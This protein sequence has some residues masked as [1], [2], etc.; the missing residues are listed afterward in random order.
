MGGFSCACCV[1][2][3]SIRYFGPHVPGAPTW[4]A[5]AVAA[6][7]R[8]VVMAPNQMC[9]PLINIQGGWGGS[10]GVDT[11]GP[12]P[13]QAMLSSMRCSHMPSCAS[14]ASPSMHVISPG[15]HQ[16]DIP[17][18]ASLSNPLVCMCSRE[19]QLSYHMVSMTVISCSI[20]SPGMHNGFLFFCLVHILRSID[21]HL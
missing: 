17:W 15:M 2:L 13:P 14:V 5:A 3:V 19:R 20:M 10:P 9:P 18:C 6:W 4:E 16:R 12:P 1:T 7:R 8:A 21:W 11:P